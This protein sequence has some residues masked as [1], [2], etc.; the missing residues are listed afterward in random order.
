[1]GALRGA[2]RGGESEKRHSLGDSPATDPHQEGRLGGWQM[3][4]P[5]H[6]H[7]WGDGTFMATA[8]EVGRIGQALVVSG[9]ETGLLLLLLLIERIP[10]LSSS[11]ALKATY[12][13]KILLQ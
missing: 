10:R 6:V 7:I 8:R 13:I 11:R 2:A 4:R 12:N 5:G 1:M 9:A 3:A